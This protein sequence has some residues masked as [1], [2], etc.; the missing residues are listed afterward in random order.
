MCHWVEELCVRAISFVAHFE[1]TFSHSNALGIFRSYPLLSYDLLV[2]VVSLLLVAKETFIIETV[3]KV[4][5]SL[6]VWPLC[7]DRKR[8]YRLRRLTWRTLA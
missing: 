4:L 1:K 6:F 8:N 2:N 7:R 5:T 3:P